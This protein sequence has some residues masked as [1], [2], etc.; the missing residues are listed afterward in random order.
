M[1]FHTGTKGRKGITDKKYFSTF[2]LLK[3]K[4]F[5]E[6][7]QNFFLFWGFCVYFSH[8]KNEVLCVI[9]FSPLQDSGHII[10]KLIIVISLFL[11]CVKNR[12]KKIFFTVFKAHSV[13]KLI[14]S[15]HSYVILWL[16]LLNLHSLFNTQIFT[17]RKKFYY[18]NVINY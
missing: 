16:K 18:Y 4:F 15:F 9:L 6:N 12:H 7:S 13:V 2:A 10:N 8:F 11:F 1:F 3:F 5:Y 14:L 17:L